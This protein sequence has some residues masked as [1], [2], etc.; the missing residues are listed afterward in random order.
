MSAHSCSAWA[1]KPCG[2]T[3]APARPIQATRTTPTCCARSAINSFSDHPQVAQSE[4]CYQL[5]SVLGHHKV[6]LIEKHAFARA[7]GDKFESGGGEADLLHIRLTFRRLIGCQG[8]SER[9]YLVRRRVVLK[10][11]TPVFLASQA[12]AVVA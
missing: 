10:R 2:P 3:A 9:A 11:I 12:N 8:F 1:S 4:Q 5:R 7:L 6:H